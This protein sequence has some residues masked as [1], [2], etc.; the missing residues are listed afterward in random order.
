MELYI[1]RHGIAEEGRL[2]QRD[3]ERALTDEGRRKLR[4][5]LR[6]AQRAGLSPDLIIS[7]PYLRAVETA[8]V[9]I[10]ILRYKGTLSQT[11]VLIPSSE[12]ATVWQEVRT[13]RDASSL[14]LVGHEPLLS[15]VAGYVLGAP[16]LLV[17]MK[18][19]ALI[20]VDLES[21][22]TQPRGVLKWMLTPKLV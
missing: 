19:A 13:H 16:T 15:Q 10:D 14:M 9:A 11:P 17:D 18:K 20:R 2:G 8:E 1:L 6:V 3:S 21:F 7:S 12:P 4:E 5:V 22:G